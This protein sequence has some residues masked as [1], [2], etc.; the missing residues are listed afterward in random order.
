MHFDGA[1]PISLLHVALFGVKIGKVLYICRCI[2]VHV[3]KMSYAEPGLTL[4][5][6]FLVGPSNSTTI[7]DV[8]RII[9]L[10]DLIKIY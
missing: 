6:Q 5:F 8:V 7:L 4:G 3:P 1:I 9:Q 2:H 10:L